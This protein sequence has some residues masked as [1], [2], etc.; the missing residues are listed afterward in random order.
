MG[1]VVQDDVPASDPAYDNTNTILK[2]NLLQPPE[3]RPCPND[4][5]V[6]RRGAVLRGVE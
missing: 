5:K 6:G 2:I 1:D 3:C 4:R